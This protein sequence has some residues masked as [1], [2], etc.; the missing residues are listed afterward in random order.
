MGEEDLINDQDL[1][2]LLQKRREAAAARQ[3]AI[4]NGNPLGRLIAGAAGGIE[5]AVKGGSGAAGAQSGMNFVDERARKLAAIQSAQDTAGMGDLVKIAQMRQQR[6]LAAQQQQHALDQMKEGKR[7]DLEKERELY[8]MKAAQRNIELAMMSGDKKAQADAINAYKVMEIAQRDRSNLMTDTRIR[9]IEGARSQ[10]KDTQFD[11]MDKRLRDL[12]D[13]RQAGATQRAG[14][15]ADAKVKGAGINAAAKAAP[16]PIK[17]AVPKA[18]RDTSGMPIVYGYEVLEGASPTDQDAKEVKKIS[19]GMNGANTALNR[20]R[21]ALKSSPNGV[22][23]LPFT[24]DRANLDSIAKSVVIDMKEAANLGALAGPDMDLVLGMMGDPL[25]VKAAAMGTDEYLK[26][27]DQAQA[28]I[29]SKH[30]EK[31]KAYGFVPK[32]GTL[33]SPEKSQQSG[34]SLPPV[35]EVTI[36]GKKVRFMLMPNGKYQ[37]EIL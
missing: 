32:I 15:G 36:Q 35:K 21:S 23:S 7:L 24:S 5:A 34:G 28:L 27:L 1:L 16:K 3:S 10:Q 2:A 17:A 25:G 8:P 12:E 9:D 33:P 37:Q 19:S 26:V 4:E 29:N 6:N 13:K 18:G 20:L 30:A 11:L 14:I 22:R 31:M